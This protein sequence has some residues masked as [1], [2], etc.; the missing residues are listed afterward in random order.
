LGTALLLKPLVDI[1][2]AFD[3][4]GRSIRAAAE[5]RTGR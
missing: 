4:G 3:A 5:R 2:G 1:G